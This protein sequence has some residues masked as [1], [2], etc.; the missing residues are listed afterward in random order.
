MTREEAIQILETVFKSDET[1]N[2]YDSVT[3]QAL[4]M[5]ISALHFE[6]DCRNCMWREKYEEQTEPSDLISRADVLGYI[7]RVTN[8]GLGRNK[9]LDYIGK[10]VERMPSVSV[11]PKKIPLHSCDMTIKQEEPIVVKCEMCYA[12]EDFTE[13]ARKVRKENPNQNIVVIPY[14]AE[15]VDYVPLNY[16]ELT[17]EARAKMKGGAE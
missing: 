13:W 11:E 15:C 7:E 6:A 4:N 8:C 3:H 9:S 16:V 12:D 5:A 2:Y 14:N 17:E 1:Y 10:Y